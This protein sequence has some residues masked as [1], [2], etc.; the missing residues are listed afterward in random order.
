M[1]KTIK[2]KITNTPTALAGLALGISGLGLLWDTTAHLH[3]QVQMCSAIVASIL[4][5]LL[6]VKF[7]IRPKALLQDLAHPT[8]GSVVPTFAMTLMIISKAI[9]LFVSVNL[10][11]SLWLIAIALHLIFLCLFSYHR[12]VEFK[13][14]HLIPGWFVPP[15][16]IV[17]AAV[18]IPNTSMLPIATALVTFGIASYAILLPF[19]LYRLIF[20]AEIDDQAKP[21]IAIL[22]AP[23]SLSLAGYL[24][25][26]AQPSPLIVAILLGIG[27][28]MTSVVYLSFFKLMRLPFTPG[29]SAFTFPTV[30]SATALFKTIHLATKMGIDTHYIQQ[31][32][33]LAN[34][35]LCAT[36]MVVCY[37]TYKFLQQVIIKK[38]T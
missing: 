33:V 19:M 15:V 29:F 34:I 17:V 7:S 23:A 18:A 21:T 32:S 6:I 27:I 8:I 24:T 26:I 35:E 1:I 9:T 22:A 30:I 20:C 28:L 2:Q 36:T 13:V 11:I 5:L 14:H 25:V 3:G 10:G 38:T 16:G 4:L 12:I 31:L 37:V